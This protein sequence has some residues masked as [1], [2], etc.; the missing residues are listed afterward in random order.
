MRSINNLTFFFFTFSLPSSKPTEIIEQLDL[1]IPGNLN[2]YINTNVLSILEKR[3]PDT[4]A[5][6]IHSICFNFP[7]VFWLILHI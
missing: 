2:K 5:E 6:G 1:Q 3:A 7:E 4:C